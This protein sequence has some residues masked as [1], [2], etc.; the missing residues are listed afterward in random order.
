MAKRL[1]LEEVER[2]IFEDSDEEF[3]SGSDDDF[4]DICDETT[5]VTNCNYCIIIMY[6][7]L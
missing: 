4:H 7:Y 5:M 3:F 1:S 2:C 6:N